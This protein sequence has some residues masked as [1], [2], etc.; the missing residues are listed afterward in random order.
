MSD[1]EKLREAIRRSYKGELSTGA[2]L[3][4]MRTMRTVYEGDLLRL[5]D[6]AE[7]TLPKTKMVETWHVEAVAHDNEPAIFVRLTEVAASNLA[8]SFHGVGHWS[9]IRVTGPHQQ[10]VPA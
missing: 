6:A 1:H 5:R 10:E 3:G 9:C 7:S 4:D 8:A 2:P